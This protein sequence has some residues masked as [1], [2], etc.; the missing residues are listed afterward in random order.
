MARETRPRPVVDSL[1]W[2][3]AAAAGRRPRVGPLRSG[4]GAGRF[5]HGEWT[6]LL[7]RFTHIDGTI[8]YGTMVRVRRLVEVYLRRLAEADPETFADA[9]DQL[10][11]Y[12]NAYNAIAVHQVL[13]SYPVRSIRQI[14]GALTRP[15]PIGRRNVSLNILHAS[16][17]RTFGDPRI[18][19]AINPATR[20]SGPLQPQAFSGS[21]LQQELDAAM[22]RLLNDPAHGARLEVKTKSIYISS[23]FRLF[24]GDFLQPH[25]MPSLVGLVAG[26]M[27]TAPLVMVVAP[28]LPSELAI[29]VRQNQLDVRF[30][31]YVWTLN[32]RVSGY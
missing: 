27:N 9:D 18:H 21:G 32:D 14:P 28:Y 15:Y 7:S 11:F 23:I 10:A 1:T 17:L 5:Q 29:A 30:L 6:A 13:R 12:L 4:I 25:T 22:R 20:G 19:A 24:G 16:I 2:L 26:W 3:T 8:D 31:P